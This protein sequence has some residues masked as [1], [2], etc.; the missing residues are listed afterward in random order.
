M[1]PEAGCRRQAAAPRLGHWPRRVESVRPIGPAPFQKRA[2]RPPCFLLPAP[3]TLLPAPCFLHHLAGPCFKTAVPASRSLLLVACFKSGLAGHP[4]SRI[5]HPA[6]LVLVAGTPWLVLVLV[7][8]F[9][10]G[11][12][13]GWWP[14]ML[15][16]MLAGP[17]NS[18]KLASNRG[19]G[20]AT[21]RRWRATAGPCRCIQKASCIPIPDSCCMGAG[22]LPLVQLSCTAK[23][24]TMF[25]VVGS[26]V[27]RQNNTTNLF[28][29]QIE[30]NFSP[31]IHYK[32]RGL[33]HFSGCFMTTP[34][35]KSW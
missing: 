6:W 10:S 11:L 16:S 7:A 15:A 29:G 24:T 17:S 19:A 32:I 25:A 35:K 22:R 13:G 18:S 12:A 4:A 30:N 23:A 2:C 26:K 9:K 31:S 5:P 20:G 34:P 33:L 3:C 28:W 8:R 27:C 21:R 1:R 14:S